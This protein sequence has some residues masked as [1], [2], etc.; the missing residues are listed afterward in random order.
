MSAQVIPGGFLAVDTFFLMSG[1]LLS[2]V[3][4]PQ[5]DAGTLSDLGR[6]ITGSSG[7]RGSW[8]LK[9]YVHRYLRLTPTLA[10]ATLMFWKVVPLLGSGAGWWPVAAAQEESCRR[11]VCGYWW[12]EVTYTQA[13]LPWPPLSDGCTGV[14]WYLSDDTLYFLAGVP[15]LALYHRAPRVGATIAAVVA[16]VSTLFTLVWYGF[17]DNISFTVFARVVKPDGWGIVYAAPWTRCPT[18]L[19]GALCGMV[20]HSKFRGR[21]GNN[22]G[23]VSTTAGGGSRIGAAGKGGSTHG[24]SSHGSG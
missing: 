1:F 11:R 8:M 23:V 18:Y 15:L 10:F 21:V 6:S 9:A 3:L 22:N 24:A 4:L 5:L 14:S 20:W 16:V 17:H 13:F 12:T 19:V 7:W 2:S